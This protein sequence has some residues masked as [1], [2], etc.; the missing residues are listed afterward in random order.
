MIEHFQCCRTEIR[1][2]KGTFKSGDLFTI[3]QDN[4]SI[5]KFSSYGWN[6]N[7]IGNDSID[8]GAIAIINFRI[9]KID[10]NSNIMFSAA[11][12]S[13]NQKR[14]NLYQSC[15]CYLN[16]TLGGLYCQSPLSYI[17]YSFLNQNHFSEGTVITMIVDTNI[18]KISFKINWGLVKTGYHIIIFNEPI[19]PCVLLYTKGNSVTITN[20][21]SPIPIK[22]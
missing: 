4:K 10:S 9:E 8:K 7:I 3:S 16:S 19:V 22:N 20:P 5:T 1:K 14:V 6:A 11:P 2:Y 15:G 18:G 21:Q 17:D 12:I 13:I